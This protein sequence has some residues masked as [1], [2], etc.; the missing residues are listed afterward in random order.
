MILASELLAYAKPLFNSH[1]PSS[2]KTTTSLSTSVN[3]MTTFI[4]HLFVVNLLFFLPSRY[5]W[6]LPLNFVC[7]GLIYDISDL[8]TC[9]DCTVPVIYTLVVII[10][11]HSDDVIE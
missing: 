7:Q 8:N 4:S 6:V 11:T 10:N 1:P 5:L 3:H 9:E 2:L